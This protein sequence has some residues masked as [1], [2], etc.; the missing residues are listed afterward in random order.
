MEVLT[1][2]YFDGETQCE[3]YIAYE[4]STLSPQPCILVAHDWGGR[5][6]FAC[7]KARLLAQLGYV[8]F[9]L[10]MYGHAEQTEDKTKKRALMTPFL[11]DRSLLARRILAA[12]QHVT[13]L[14]FV[15]PHKIA[16]I[17][18]CFGGLCVLDL[19]RQGA[20]VKGVAS[21]HGML[22]PPLEQIIHR[23][24]S[25]VLILH[26][27]D[28]PLCK[29][30]ELDAFAREMTKAQTDWQLHIYGNTL[31]SF[32]NPKA[33]DPSMG[34]KYEKQAEHRSWQATLQFLDA[35]LSY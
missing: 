15:N 5:N 17:G 4:P 6:D 26:G 25:K 22:Y 13:E 14:P 18:Y 16:A 31:H 29:P 10:D 7:E 32:T 11:Q 1:S 35:C 12:Y 28:D 21:F 20:C 27:Y 3:G 34:L 19:A 9:A 24:K 2:I 33:D 30:N 8:G 23:I